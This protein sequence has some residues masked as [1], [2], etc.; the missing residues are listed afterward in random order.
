MELMSFTVVEVLLPLNV[1]ILETL[2]PI[3]VILESDFIF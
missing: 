3:L 2:G 1:N